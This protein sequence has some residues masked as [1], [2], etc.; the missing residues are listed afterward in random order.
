VIFY[1]SY[2]SLSVHIGFYKT[3]TT[4]LQKQVFPKLKT[5]EF[6]GGNEA[7]EFFYDIMF[8]DDLYYN[9]DKHINYF[10]EFSSHKSVLFSHE[11]LSGFIHFIDITNRSLVAHRLYN[12]GF[13][14]IIITIRNQFEAIESLYSEY[15]KIGGV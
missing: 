3:G 1:I 11:A 2:M 7:L 12:I 8:T 14:K 15:I 6:Y 13:S 9:K 10:G 5:T 4:T